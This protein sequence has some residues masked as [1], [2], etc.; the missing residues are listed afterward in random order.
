[1][2]PQNLMPVVFTALI[3]LAIYRRVRRNVGR[4]LLRPAQLGWRIALFAIVGAL[5]LVVSLR[6]LPLFGAL[7][8]G[9]AAGGV[10]A[11]YGLQHTL[12]EATP[13]GRYYTPHTYIGAFV[14]ALFLG[15]IA[16][17]LFELYTTSHA[18]AAPGGAFAAYQRSP[19]TLGI[20]GVLVGYY[21]GYYAGI[22]HRNRAAPPASPAS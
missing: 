7:A 2:D 15:R 13:Q 17:R 3:A 19:L 6:E 5:M 21:V 9:I 4:Q 16:W 14:S 8:G 22:L 12:F 10:L 20:F 18:I 1:M 11:W